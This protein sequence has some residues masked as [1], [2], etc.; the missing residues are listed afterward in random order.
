MNSSEIFDKA[1]WPLFTPGLHWAL[2]DEIQNIAALSSLDDDSAEFSID[3][4]NLP[5]GT[6]GLWH[7]NALRD[8]TFN[9]EDWPLKLKEKIESVTLC[10]GSKALQTLSFVNDDENTMFTMFSNE[11]IMPLFVVD[12]D[13]LKISIQFKESLGPER[14]LVPKRCLGATGLLVR[15]KER[16]KA[17]FVA[18]SKESVLTWD[19]HQSHVFSSAS[20]MK[21]PFFDVDQDTRSKKH[22]YGGHNGG[23]DVGPNVGPN[24]GSDAKG[25]E[26]DLD[27]DDTNFETMWNVLRLRQC[28]SP[29]PDALE[30]DAAPGTEEELP[31]AETIVMAETF[32]LHEMPSP[33]GPDGLLTPRRH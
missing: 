30:T 28:L 9:L 11:F 5:D 19:G 25:C 6:M 24:G 16:Q 26:F 31:S 8:I 13:D 14:R 18:G 3:T 10:L 7:F 23:P 4:Q 20:S 12:D 32:E 33:L 27:D 1:I 15:I 29:G 17:F 22:E 21:R 2:S